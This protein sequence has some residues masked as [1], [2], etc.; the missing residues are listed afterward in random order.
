MLTTDSVKVTEPGIERSTEALANYK[1][2]HS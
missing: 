2:S 1:F